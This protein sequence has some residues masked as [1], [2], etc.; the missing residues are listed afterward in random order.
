MR[1]PQVFR[2]RI[3]QECDVALNPDQAAIRAFE[4]GDGSPIPIPSAMARAL[5]GSIVAVG[6]A[7][8]ELT[9]L[10][11]PGAAFQ[12]AAGVVQGG[13]VS[14]MLDFAAAFALLAALED[15]KSTAPAS[16]TVS[17]LRPVPQGELMVRGTVEKAGRSLGYARAAVTVAGTTEPLATA[18]ATMAVVEVYRPP[19]AG[20][21]HLCQRYRLESQCGEQDEAAS[22][23]HAQDV[24]ASAKEI[25]REGGERSQRIARGGAEHGA[26]RPPDS[27][28]TALLVSLP[29]SAFCETV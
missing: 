21:G 3:E 17:F 16:L 18:M 23:D 6:P 8:G 28:G 15:G 27:H 12:Q 20:P 19:P 4:K 7:R 26:E 1:N 25:E 24:F 2:E 14:A 11:R 9:L 5:D 22:Q 13:A 29:P 10:F